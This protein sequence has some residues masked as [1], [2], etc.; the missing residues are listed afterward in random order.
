MILKK[1]GSIT[2][3]VIL[4]NLYTYEYL[5]QFDWRGEKRA[6]LYSK[7]LRSQLGGVCKRN[8]KILHC[9]RGKHISTIGV[10][11]C[12]CRADSPQLGL[13][14]A[15]VHREK[16]RSPR[17][18]WKSSLDL[19]LFQP[20]H[21]CLKVVMVGWSM[22]MAFSRPAWAT[23]WDKIV[24]DCSSVIEA[25]TQSQIFLRIEGQL[26]CFKQLWSYRTL[27]FSTHPWIKTLSSAA[28]NWNSNEVVTRFQ[29]EL[30]SAVQ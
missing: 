11:L 26:L 27:T 2:I 1:N 14:G 13:W 6:E 3:S 16:L 4:M 24:C 5:V 10:A 25:K 19:S 7:H 17:R 22:G 28:R 30:A 15:E 18:A 9:R 29:Y 20:Q 8:P 12:M 23:Q 21:W